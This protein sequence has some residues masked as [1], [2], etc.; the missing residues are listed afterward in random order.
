MLD[1]VTRMHSATLA[2][3]RGC[4]VKGP[5]RGCDAEIAAPRRAAGASPRSGGQPEAAA[6]LGTQFRGSPSPADS[7]ARP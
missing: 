5:A 2:A 3:V 1:D 6:G 7:S 4:R